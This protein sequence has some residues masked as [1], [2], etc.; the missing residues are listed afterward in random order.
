[1]PAATIACDTETWE[2]VFRV[3]EPV[4]IDDLEAQTESAG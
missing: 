2:N 3:D 4:P 1:M